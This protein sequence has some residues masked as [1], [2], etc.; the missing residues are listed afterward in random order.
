MKIGLVTF[1]NVHNFGAVLQAWALVQALRKVG[2]DVEVLDYHSPSHAEKFKRRGLKAW[3]PS[4]GRISFNRFVRSQLPLSP[5]LADRESM[6][7]YVKAGRFEGL[8]CGSDQVWMHASHMKLDPTYFLDLP[9]VEDLRRISYAPSC[10]D[11]GSYDERA[12]DVRRWIDRFNAVSVRDEN[13]RRLVTGLG[14]TDV[15]RVV[16]PTLLGDFRSLVGEVDPSKGGVVVVGSVG[17]GVAACARKVADR[18]GVKLIAA[19]SRCEVADVRLRFIN[20][21]QWVRQIAGAR[22]VISSLF[23]GT[24][25]SMAFRRP[26]V[27]VPSSGRTMKLKDLLTRMNLLER[28]VP[29]GKD[30]KCEIADSMFYLDYTPAEPVLSEDIETSWRFLREATQ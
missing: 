24:I 6:S 17:S 16:D 4:P 5:R 29:I 26:F 8:V 11:M 18:L 10:G 22:L 23:H 28:F 30:G 20:P 27:S 9:G 2:C 1:H 7:R 14:F 15:T 3:I 12:D 25:L 21:G 13:A 19:G